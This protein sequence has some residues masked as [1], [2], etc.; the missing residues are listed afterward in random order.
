MFAGYIQ[1]KL[2]TS[3]KIIKNQ[4]GEIYNNREKKKTF[5]GRRSAR[6]KYSIKKWFI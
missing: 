5:E 2:Q 3:E 6:L 4:K 1:L